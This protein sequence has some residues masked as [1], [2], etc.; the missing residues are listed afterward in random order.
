MILGILWLHVVKAF[1]VFDVRILLFLSACCFLFL[2]LECFGSLLSIRMVG[3][4]EEFWSF[5]FRL[6][7]SKES[8][9]GLAKV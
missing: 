2:A 8:R 7:E 9:G 3:V 4:I 1:G 5:R 6:I